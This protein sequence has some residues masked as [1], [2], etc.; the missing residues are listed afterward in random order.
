MT[1]GRITLA[2]LALVVLISLVDRVR[3]ARR[4]TVGRVVIA[5]VRAY[6]K[7]ISPVRPPACR[8]SPSCSAYAITAIE[9]HGALRG[10]WLT[11]RRLL[12]CGPWHPGGH[13]P[14][15]PLVEK[16]G[17]DHPRTATSTQTDAA[18][19]TPTGAPRC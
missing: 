9:R 4:S 7:W 17:A 13:D 19:S 18:T 10:G 2:I 8:F 3:G 11:T 12:R 16:A 6:Q 14:V 1:S 5:V 15:P